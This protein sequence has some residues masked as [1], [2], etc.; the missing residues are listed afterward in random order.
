M[1]SVEHMSTVYV[2]TNTAQYAAGLCCMDISKLMFSWFSIKTPILFSEKLLSVQ[3]KLSLYHCMG[4]FYLPWGHCKWLASSYISKY[5]Q[6]PS[7][8]KQ[9]SEFSTWFTVFHWILQSIHAVS[10]W[11]SMVAK[12]CSLLC[13]KAHNHFT[14]FSYYSSLFVHAVFLL[15]S[16]ELYLSLSA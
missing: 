7:K 12:E 14:L 15:T 11:Q 2:L 9:P 3:L 16:S 13:G 10:S 8:P 1:S 5:R 6:L 4:L